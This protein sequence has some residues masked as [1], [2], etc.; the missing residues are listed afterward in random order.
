MPQWVIVESGSTRLRAKMLKVHLRQ[1]E[2]QMH[3]V[4][5]SKEVQHMIN[6]LCFTLTIFS[7]DFFEFEHYVSISL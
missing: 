7:F 4:V 5:N 2:P 6:G 1:F 3:S